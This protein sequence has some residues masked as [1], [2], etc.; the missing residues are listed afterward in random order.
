VAVGDGIVVAAS[1]GQEALLRFAVE[2]RR[3]ATEMTA[4]AAPTDHVGA[5]WPSAFGGSAER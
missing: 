5:Q 1:S 3:R 4:L 2:R